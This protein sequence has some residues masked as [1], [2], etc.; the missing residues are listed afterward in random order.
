MFQLS[1]TKEPFVGFSLIEFGDHDRY[2]C[3]FFWDYIQK[4]ILIKFPCSKIMFF[5]RAKWIT[6]FQ[7]ITSEFFNLGLKIN[8]QGTNS[9]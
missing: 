1:L 7:V 2:I 8:I 5:E 3:G 6:S 4:L 9:P